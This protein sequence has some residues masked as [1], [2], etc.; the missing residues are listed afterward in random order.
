MIRVRLI[1]EYRTVRGNRTRV[2]KCSCG[3][4]YV[5]YMNMKNHLM[6]DH[7]ISKKEAR[8]LLTLEKNGGL[9]IDER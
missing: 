5:G 2:F 8:K 1:D 3:K 7:G 9:L 6:R 4:T